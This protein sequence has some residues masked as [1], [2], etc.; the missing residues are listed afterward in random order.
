MPRFAANLSMMF[1]EHAFLDRFAAAAD[2]GFE[3]VEFL[4]PYEVAATVVA[5]RLQA[6]GLQQALFNLPPGD[7]AAGERG[8]AAL[9]GRAAEFASALDKALDYAEALACKRLHVMAGIVPAGT[10]PQA[11]EGTYLDNLTYASARA[12]EAGIT[13]LIEP[14]NGRDM[15][16]YF[17]HRLDHARRIIERVNAGN[18]ALQFDFYHTQIT[19][20]DLATN[21]RQ[22]LGIT[23]HVQ[24][25]GVPE[26]HE[27]DVGEINYRYLFDAID[28]SGYAG[29]VGCEYRPRGGTREGLRWLDAY[30]AA[31]VV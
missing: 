12:A 14:I 23:G 9:P 16:G 6:A 21:F 8:L 26:R 5:Q 30:R 20:G 1:N 27:P 25:A 4:F 17:L 28:A 24:I 19:H 11:C 3:A 29:F 31:N 10:D 22:Y 15:P 2:A 18:L 13:L 7:W